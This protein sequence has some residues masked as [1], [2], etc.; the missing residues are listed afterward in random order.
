MVTSVGAEALPFL[1]A[2]GVLPASLLFF[3]FFKVMVRAAPAQ[4]CCRP[5]PACLPLHFIHH[6]YDMIINPVFLDLHARKSCWSLHLLNSQL[7]LVIEPLPA[8]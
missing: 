3:T 5:L 1:E 8:A 4:P 6:L 7:A 2:Y